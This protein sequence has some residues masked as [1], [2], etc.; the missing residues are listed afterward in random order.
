MCLPT[1]ELQG[2]KGNTEE[3]KCVHIDFSVEAKNN[4]FSPSWDLVLPKYQM[5]GRVFFFFIRQRNYWSLIS[6]HKLT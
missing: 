5:I 4:D 3:G 1:D 2:K 6:L